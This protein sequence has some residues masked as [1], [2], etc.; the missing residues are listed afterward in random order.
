MQERPAVGCVKGIVQ[1]P[2]AECE[3]FRLANCDQPLQY[4]EGYAI[5]M[6]AMVNHVYDV[7][8]ASPS[9]ENDRH[10]LLLGT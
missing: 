4:R 8:V 9:P 10:P 6:Q 1:V 7:I 5:T 3:P 2:F